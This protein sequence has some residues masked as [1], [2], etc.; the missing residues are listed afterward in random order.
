M[1]RLWVLASALAAATILFIVSVVHDSA[2]LRT[3]GQAMAQ[4]TAEQVAAL[5]SGRL[6]VLALEVFAPTMP[7]ARSIPVSDG[8]T[9]DRLVAAQR[10]AARCQCRDTLPVSAFFRWD[11]ATGALDVRQTGNPVAAPRP[12]RET[13]AAIARN[14]AGRA[15][16]KRQSAVHL[17]VAPS[18][19]SQSVVAVVQDDASGRAAVV[20][21]ALVATRPLF[22]S[23]FEHSAP[24]SAAMHSTSGITHLD[25]LSLA[26]ST[27]G[28]VPVFGAIGADRR[29]RGSITPRGPLDGLLVTA[30]PPP[31]QLAH[32]LFVSRAELA[33]LAILIV[34]TILVIAF[35]AASSRRELMLAQ[36]RSNFIAGVSHDLRMPLALVLIA[37]ETLALQRERDEADRL[38]L[39]RSIVRE[40][41]RLVGLVDNVMLFSRSGAV[42][43]TARLR[44][45]DVDAVLT[46]VV[47]SVQLAVDDAQQTITVRGLTELSA[48]ADARLVRQALVNLVDNALKY[49]APGQSIRLGAERSGRAVHLYVDDDGP[50]VP[51]TERARVFK[52]YERLARDASSERTGTGLGLAVVHQIAAACNGRV[53]LEDRAGGGT[54]AV[55]ELGADTSASTADTPAT[56]LAAELV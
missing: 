14:E 49:G 32:Q 36:A 40:S 52:P 5:V 53:W 26:L 46:A 6:E 17:A 23:M 28:G 37:G 29:F 18:L 55:L 4:S 41:R 35:A 39:A 38:S 7:W 31:E 27:I 3:A 19:G 34:A 43:L 9:V 42:T 30:A 1:R 51:A 2:R 56:T 12:T 54:R 8:S 16:L 50:G 25:T 15:R 10:D 45:V 24:N 44:P 20:Y 21:G 22:A 47:E 48:L 33:H 13:L 11:A